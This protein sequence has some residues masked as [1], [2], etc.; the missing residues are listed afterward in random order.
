MT[1]VLAEISKGN[2]PK[3]SKFI[4]N[5]FDDKILYWILLSLA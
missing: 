5:L 1:V 4:V 3:N 2:W